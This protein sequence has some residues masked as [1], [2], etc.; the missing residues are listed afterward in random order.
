M[1][2][3]T[4]GRSTR[5]QIG[6]IADTHGSMR[7]EA[8]EALRGVDHVLHAGDAGRA[9]VLGAWRALAPVTAVRGN[10]DV[11]PIVSALAE[12]ET[13]ELGG[14]RFEI[15]HVKSDARAAPGTRVIVSGHSHRP[16]IEERDG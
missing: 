11:G 12:R 2:A 14:V 13:I 3:H 15:V 6:V 4:S 16:S 8:I 9:S 7:P 1:G 10:G 5:M